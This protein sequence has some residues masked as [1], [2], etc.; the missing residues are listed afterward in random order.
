MLCKDDNFSDME[1]YIPFRIIVNKNQAASNNTKDQQ[2]L[3]RLKY[4]HLKPIKILKIE[5]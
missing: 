1:V 4:V 5:I 3:H 2:D